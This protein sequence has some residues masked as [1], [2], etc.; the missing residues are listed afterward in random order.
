[1]ELETVVKCA[2]CWEAE[3]SNTE[4]LYPETRVLIA[5]KGTVALV[6]DR[7]SRWW[8]FEPVVNYVSWWEAESRT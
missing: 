6:I 8:T 7:N 5:A 1:M 2:G 3:K 4:N